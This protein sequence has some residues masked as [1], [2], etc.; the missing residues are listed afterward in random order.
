MRE[1]RPASSPTRSRSRRKEAKHPNEHRRWVS[2]P[3]SAAGHFSSD[4]D[5]AR[6]SGRA[7]L[8]E[9]ADGG[10]LRIGGKTG[11]DHRLVGIQLVRDRRAGP[12]A[13]ALMV[14]VPVQ[15]PVTNPAIDRIAADAEF[16]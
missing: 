13:H 7:Y 1:G 12:V 3:P 9:E 6:I 4:V 8:L 2:F 15:L 10:E 14:Q 5:T 16:S 11:K